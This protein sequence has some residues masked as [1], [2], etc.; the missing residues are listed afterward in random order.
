MIPLDKRHVW[1]VLA[2]WVS[3]YTSERPHSALGPRLPDDRARQAALTGHCLPA[4]HRVVAR[5]RDDGGAAQTASARADH[6]V[7]VS[8]SRCCVI[9]SCES[10]SAGDRRRR[11]ER[12]VSRQGRRGGPIHRIWLLHLLVNDFSGEG[13]AGEICCWTTALVKVTVAN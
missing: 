10:A 7:E 3:H 1:S 11:R 9:R 8:R 13:G 12:P 2:E 5:E 4:T 6:L